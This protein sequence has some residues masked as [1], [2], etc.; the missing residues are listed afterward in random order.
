VDVDERLT[1]EYEQRT[2]LL[3]ALTDVRFRLLAFV[4]TIAGAAVAI[5]GHPRPAVDLIAIGGLGLFATI[6]IFL[7]ELGNSEL[8]V[9]AAERAATLEREL[10]L[11]SIQAG[12]QRDLG[13]AFVYAA[14]LGGWTYLVAWGVLHALGVGSAQ[15]TGAVIGAVAGLVVIG[16][17]LR[18]H[19]GATKR[20]RD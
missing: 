15:A 3:G 5:V 12:R 8:S 11:T 14:A 20:R 9:A 1:F 6:G 17:V 10:G 13:L 4:P 16:L 18:V 2:Q 19:P 7:Y